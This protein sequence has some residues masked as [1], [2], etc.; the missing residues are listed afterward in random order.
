MKSK[1]AKYS[2]TKKIL[3]SQIR[4]I[5]LSRY[6]FAANYNFIEHRI[7]EQP[8]SMDDMDHPRYYED[9]G[10]CMLLV[11]LPGK[12]DRQKRDDFFAEVEQ[13]A[14]NLT[15][16]EGTR[17]RREASLYMRE[18]LLEKVEALTAEVALLNIRVA[19]CSETATRCSELFTVAKNESAISPQFK[20]VW[21][22]V[23]A[24]VEG[25]KA[26]NTTL[27]NFAKKAEEQWQ[28]L[29]FGAI[30]SALSILIA[31]LWAA[32]DNN[33][34]KN[35]RKKNGLD[36]HWYCKVSNIEQKQFAA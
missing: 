27:G 24:F 35:Y 2:N 15:V 33:V 8:L 36:T 19:K 13:M 9:F 14:D 22:K 25:Q 10:R 26:A 32:F 20:V 31:T 4:Q 5:I 1:F 12:T 29:P 34:A 21:E 30:V 6:Y 3:T 18:K 17:M 7:V 28:Q 11:D 23:L 16:K